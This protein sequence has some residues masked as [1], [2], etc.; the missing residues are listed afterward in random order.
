MA[1]AGPY[2]DHFSNGKILADALNRTAGISAT[3]PCVVGDAVAGHGCEEAFASPTLREDVDVLLICAQSLSTSP[4]SGLLSFLSSLS[5]LAL[6]LNPLSLRIVHGLR[7]RGLGL[8]DADTYE[9]PERGTLTAEQWAGLFSFV[10]N[11]GGLFALHTA[12]A[13]WMHS[14]NQ[15]VRL[16]L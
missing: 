4:H 5:F 8:A 10:E 3:L 1:T 12:S 13:C 14:C 15:T 6:I 2:H 7:V 9:N 11:G 16:L